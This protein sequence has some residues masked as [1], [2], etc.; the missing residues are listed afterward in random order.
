MIDW[1]LAKDFIRALLSLDP[2]QRPTAEE[3]LKHQWIV[4]NVAKDVDL[5]GDFIENFN[6]RKTFK[7][8]VKLVQ[9][10]NQLRTTQR[11]SSDFEE[12]T[13]KQSEKVEKSEKSENSENP[14]SKKRELHAVV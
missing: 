1:L 11:F 7:K 13:G 5:L 3:A 8:A 2:S 14:E 12:E 9:V 4:G 6:A 10:A